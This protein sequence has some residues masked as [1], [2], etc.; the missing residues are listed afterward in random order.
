MPTRPILVFDV[1]ETLLDL[2]HLCPLFDEIFGDA[3]VMRDWF[4]QLILYSQTLTITGLKSDFGTLAVGVLRM[5]GNIR[6]VPV[7]DTHA[8][9]LRQA[10]ATMPAHPDAADALDHLRQQGFR[11]VTLTNSPPSKGP[12]AI[13]RAGLAEYFQASFSVQPVGRFKP[14][15]ETY[16]LVA[17]ALAVPSQD[18]CL[19][20][21]HVWDTIGMQ[22]LG[23]KGALVT[24]GVNAP[25]VLPDIPQPDVVASDLRALAWA[26]ADRWDGR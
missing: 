18:L 4:A 11:M 8:E 16:R 19:V 26:I 12:S 5:T 25:L 10:I 13:D 7:T 24:H 6:G 20:A 17:D 3:E 14:A 2:N 23:G 21:C 9:A 15:P 22:A 1:N